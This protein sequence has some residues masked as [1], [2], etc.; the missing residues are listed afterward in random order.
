MHPFEE[1]F[2]HNENA[3]RLRKNEALW[4]EHKSFFK[5]LLISRHLK[6]TVESIAS[7]YIQKIYRGF[8][9]RTRKDEI[10]ESC[11]FRKRIRS[12]IRDYII[13]HTDNR[14]IGII[15]TQGEHRKRYKEWRYRAAS[16][17][18]RGYRCFYSRTLV[19]KVRTEMIG[20][21]EARAVIKIQSFTRRIAAVRRTS[22]LKYN[23][24]EYMRTKAVVLVQSLFRYFL[25]KRRV[26]KRRYRLHN[27][28][29][30]IIQCCYRCH[31]AKTLLKFM[32]RKFLTFYNNDSIIAIQCLV[33]KKIS[34]VRVKRLNEIRLIHRRNYHSSRIQAIMRG[35]LT[36]NCLNRV[37]ADKTEVE[38]RMKKQ[39]NLDYVNSII[40]K[41]NKPKKLLITHGKNADELDISRHEGNHTIEVCPT[42]ISI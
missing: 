28:A 37:R 1:K 41:S 17:I 14:G 25:A 38:K 19:R 21:K 13:T 12:Q 10:T 9:I 18:Q 42:F 8:C 32:D 24:L 33:R 11:L 23:R 35:Y 3:V 4:L 26:S 6:S 30:R 5:K 20:I 7:T 15:L 2:L 22:S 39:T 29:A 36:R 31:R 27:I 16:S 40:V 34:C